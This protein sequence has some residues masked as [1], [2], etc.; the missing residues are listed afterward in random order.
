LQP[1][2][3]LEHKLSIFTT[4]DVKF[5]LVLCMTCT[6]RD[7]ELFVQFAVPYSG[8]EQFVLMS[9]GRQKY[10]LHWQFVIVFTTCMQAT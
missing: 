2:G 7:D 10:L 8:H 9:Y 5:R 1:T 3:N 6:S 4:E